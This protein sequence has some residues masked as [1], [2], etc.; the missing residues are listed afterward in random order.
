MSCDCQEQ[1]FCV[2]LG[3]TFRPTLRWA[4]DTLVSVP[5]TGITQA[6]PAVVT[7]P[8]HGMPNGWPCAVVAAQG[9]IQINAS[10]YPPRGEDWQ[11][12]TVVDVNTVQLNRVSSADYSAYTS[13]GFLIYQQPQS[14]AGVT[15]KMTVWDTP[16]E[17]DTPL[18]TLLSTSSGII[19]DPVA[20]TLT[21]ILQTAGLSWQIGYFRFDVTDNTG[22]VTQ[23]MTG[24]LTIQ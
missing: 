5:I 4:S 17:N 9:M 10:R 18:V 8:N 22:A 2:A 21:P 15:A 19:I 3:E 11:K 23:L 7:A 12:G 16:E 1:D 20:M 24:T 6:A 14:L 13:G